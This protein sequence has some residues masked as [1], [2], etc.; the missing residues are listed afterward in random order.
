MS[1]AIPAATLRRSAW[2][3]WVFVAVFAVVA[4]V[5]ATM[6]WLAVRSAPGVVAD[7]A[8]ERG[9]HYNAQLA[10]ARAQEA[11]GW[12]AVLDH[13][14]TRVNFTVNGRDGA[15][16][17]GLD[18]DLAAR[19]PVDP[20]APVALRLTETKPGR[21]SGALELPRAGQWQLEVVARRG[22][23]EFAFAKRIVFQ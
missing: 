18:V 14:A 10:A 13:D 22:A 21:Y 15:P 2:I 11:L 23:D 7:Y 8:Y 19:R 20:G 3:P 17:S 5:N 9:R 1:T 4:G 6:I 12:T 16:V